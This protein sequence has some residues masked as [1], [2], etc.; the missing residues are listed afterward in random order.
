MEINE[1]SGTR[2]N[3]FGVLT[4]TPASTPSVPALT[5]TASIHQYPLAEI[6]VGAAVTSIVQDDITNKV[7]MS[8][9][10]FVAGIID[11]VTTNEILAQW[12]AQWMT[13]FD[14]IKDQLSTEAETNLQAQI[15]DL[16]GV[17]SGAPPYADDMV[18]LG[19]HDHSRANHPKIDTGGLEDLA[20]TA[21]KIAIGGVGGTQLASGAV[22]ASKLGISSVTPDK[23]QAQA[24]TAGKIDT[25]AVTSS[26]IADGAI[27]AIGQIANN[28]LKTQHIGQQIAAIVN[29]FGGSSTNWSSA[30][31]TAQGGSQN[32]R[33]QFGRFTCAAFAQVD[34]DYSPAFSLPP[35]LM[36]S[37][38]HSLEIDYQIS[39]D[40]LKSFEE[41]FRFTHFTTG[42]TA[43]MHW[44]AIGPE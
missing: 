25:D 20:V 5:Q 29:R 21:S 11:Y 42:E 39:Y 17:G 15:W 41:N 4:G 34:I 43:D 37:D 31:T 38:I 7:G 19:A 22:S 8:A 6:L 36:M 23:I 24:V 44:I 26:K 14:D 1:D 40:P 28:L 12:E 27:N 33:I 3:S 35:W 2:A 10:P 13:W 16:A 9:T 18:I 32:F 30:G